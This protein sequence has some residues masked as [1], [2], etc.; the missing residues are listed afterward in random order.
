LGTGSAEGSGDEWNKGPAYAFMAVLE[1][2]GGVIWPEGMGSV[3]FAGCF[4][5]LVAAV[6]KGG[7]TD[8][9]VGTL[10]FC[11]PLDFFF[12]FPEVSVL[13]ANPCVFGV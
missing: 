12:F 5:A 13:A 4:L 3:I 10:S 6:E 2:L 7:G 1:S 9:V 8:F 11:L